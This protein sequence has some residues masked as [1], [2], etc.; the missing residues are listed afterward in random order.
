VKQVSHKLAG[1]A[2]NLGV[3]AAGRTAQEIEIH[4]DTGA[5]DGVDALVDRLDRALADGRSAL[6]AY[7]ATYAAEP[8]APGPTT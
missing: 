5:L 8:G 4:A 6:R 3:E 2:L 1:S 7:Q